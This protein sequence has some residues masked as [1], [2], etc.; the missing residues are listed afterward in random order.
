MVYV[1]RDQQQRLLRVSY[2]PF[3]G[4]NEVLAIE[5]PELH[6]WLKTKEEVKA[7][8]DSLNSSDLELVRVLE[9]VVIV[10]VDRGVIQY[11]DLPE[12]ARTKLDQRAIARADLEGLTH[13]VD[14][15]P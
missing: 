14:V 11:T 5:S 12:A 2:E 4:M 9:D 15:K 7:R 13:E 3:E 8:L 6:D 10:L 1:E